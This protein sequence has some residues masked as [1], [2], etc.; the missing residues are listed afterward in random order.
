MFVIYDLLLFI[1]DDSILHHHC[2]EFPYMNNF[3]SLLVSNLNTKTFNL[4]R[5][6]WN[7]Y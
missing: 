4:V 2:A 1:I 7:G 3:G 5:K 6:T